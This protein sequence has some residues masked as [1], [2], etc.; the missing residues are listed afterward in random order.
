MPPALLS[1]LQPVAAQEIRINAVKILHVLTD[2]MPGLGQIVVPDGGRQGAMVV[3]LGQAVGDIG[4]LGDLNQVN[5][6]I[7]SVLLAQQPVVAG[8]AGDLQVK[9]HVRLNTAIDV[10]PGAAV[11]QSPAICSRWSKSEA[12]PE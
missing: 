5:L 9:V 6:L 1:Y 4:I 3:D 2:Q 11:S 12:L 8:Q 10:S 7:E